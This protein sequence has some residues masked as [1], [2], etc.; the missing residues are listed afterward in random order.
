MTRINL[1]PPEK[2]KVKRKPSERSYLWLAIV[3]PVIAIVAIA[4]L[5]VQVNG[6]IAEQDKALKDKKA[7]LAEWQ[8][9]N[10]ALQQYK[11]RQDVILKLESS[12][13]AALSGRV[14]WAR[15]LNNIAITVPSD[16]WITLL[17]GTAEEGGTG[18]SVDF[19]GFALQCPNRNNKVHVYPYLPD[20]KPIANWLERMAT[21]PEFARIWLASATPARAGTANEILIDNFISTIT[22]TIT[23]TEQTGTRVIQFT[24]QAKLNPET[25]TVSG[26]KS[27]PPPASA[28]P[29]TLEEGGGIL[30]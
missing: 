21:V 16:I 2:I 14:Y 6:K 10:V 3:F 13:T 8:S 25:A 5:F 9:K 27:S 26:P 24:S 19:T 11:D 18:G 17:N 29:R 30:K 4:M 20:Y 12:V 22:P 15:I 28:A 1:L 7:E 23:T